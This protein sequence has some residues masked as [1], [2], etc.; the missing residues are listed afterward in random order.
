MLEIPIYH[1]KNIHQD[2]DPVIGSF[3]TFVEQVLDNEEFQH[4]AEEGVLKRV[5]TDGTANLSDK[6]LSVIE[7]VVDRYR[8][9][10]CKICGNQPDFDEVVSFFDLQEGYCNYHWHKHQK[11]EL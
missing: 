10:E 7:R 5:N 9:L 11:G 6:Q 8:G 1:S 2:D 3:R 4:D